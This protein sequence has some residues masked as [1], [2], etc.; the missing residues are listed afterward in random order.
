MIVYKGVRA[1]ENV[2]GEQSAY[3]VIDKLGIRPYLACDLALST[4]DRRRLWS[5]GLTDRLP[6]QAGVEALRVDRQERQGS[7][8]AVEG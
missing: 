6:G 2:P 1:C 8:G 3:S 5:T 7:T 4:A